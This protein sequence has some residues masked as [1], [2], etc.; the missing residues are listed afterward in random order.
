MVELADDITPFIDELG[1]AQA[2]PAIDSAN[3]YPRRLLP[4]EFIIHV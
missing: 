1:T 2:R 3:R 4:K